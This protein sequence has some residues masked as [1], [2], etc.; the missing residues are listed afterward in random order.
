MGT[1]VHTDVRSDGDRRTPVSCI[2]CIF[3]LVFRF[4]ARPYGCVARRAPPAGVPSRVLCGAP[5]AHRARTPM[6]R[7]GHHGPGCRPRT[8]ERGFLY[9]QRVPTFPLRRNISPPPFFFFYGKVVSTIFFFGFCG[10]GARSAPFS[11]LGQEMVWL[12]PCLSG[13][14]RAVLRDG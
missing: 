14:P 7:L 9:Q 4:E 10:F 6:P 1:A 2:Y 12:R 13:C 3:I 11:G 5:A 8:P